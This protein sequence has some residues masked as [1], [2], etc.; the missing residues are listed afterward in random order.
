M[1]LN[2]SLFELEADDIPCSQLPRN[3]S[4]KIFMLLSIMCQ[5]TRD[6]SDPVNSRQGLVLI[7]ISH[8]FP[9][10]SSRKS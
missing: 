7:S 3:G 9:F 2:S 4:R 8:T 5:I 1:R 6:V 10:L